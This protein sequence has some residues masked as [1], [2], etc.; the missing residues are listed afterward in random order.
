MRPIEK[1]KCTFKNG[2]LFSLR[3]RNTEKKN[4]DEANPYRKLEKCIDCGIM[5]D[6]TTHWVK[7]INTVFWWVVSADGEI[8]KVPI[9]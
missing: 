4:S 5:H 7:E 1:D 3:F 6:A 8:F 2:S 9:Q